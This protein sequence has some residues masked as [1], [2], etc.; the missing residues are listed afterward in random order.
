MRFPRLIFAGNYALP[1]LLSRWP[2]ALIHIL[3]FRLVL[4]LACSAL[5]TVAFLIASA[6]PLTLARRVRVFCPLVT[7]PSVLPIISFRPVVVPR[8]PPT[9]SRWVAFS[10]SLLHSQK[11]FSFFSAFSSVTLRLSSL[12]RVAPSVALCLPPSCLHLA[13]LVGIHRFPHVF[14]SSHLPSRT[15][16][17]GGRRPSCG[18]FFTGPLPLQLCDIRFAILRSLHLRSRQSTHSHTQFAPLRRLAS[19]FLLLHFVTHLV[20]L[21]PWLLLR[22]SH[23]CRSAFVYCLL[24]V[25]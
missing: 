19:L 10:H 8:H 11:P 2:R 24:G 22:L 14:W 7:Q 1:L 17:G 9:I 3:P 16:C 25:F 15:S 12:S 6:G 20:L 23:F 18:S 5:P 13:G 4:W 21:L